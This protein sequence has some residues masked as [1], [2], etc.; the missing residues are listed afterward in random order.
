MAVSRPCKLDLKS[1]DD[2]EFL[3]RLSLFGNMERPAEIGPEGLHRRRKFGVA[4]PGQADTH[5]RCTMSDRIATP[6]PL[7]TGTAPLPRTMCVARSSADRGLAPVFHRGVPGLVD[8]QHDV[9][10]LG[11]LL[12]PDR[13]GGEE[14]V[15]GRHP[16]PTLRTEQLFGRKRGI[17]DVGG[18][19]P[20]QLGGSIWLLSLT[21]DQPRGC[22]SARTTVDAAKTAVRIRGPVAP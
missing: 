22:S 18:L 19:Q 9:G 21:P 15:P 17:E 1:Q 14:R 20:R 13:V 11:H 5:G 2:N 16:E 10:L 6:W 7:A 12:E 4:P 3:G 8:G